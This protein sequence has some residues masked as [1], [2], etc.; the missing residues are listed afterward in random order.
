LGFCGKDVMNLIDFS[1]FG[2][3]D[4]TIYD[5]ILGIDFGHGE[6]SAALWKFNDNNNI[7]PKDLR[8][9]SNDLY[10]IYTALFVSNDGTYC[11]IGKEALGIDRAHGKLYTC[12]KAKPKYLNNLFENDII[13]KRELVQVFLSSVVKTLYKYNE[14]DLQGRTI[15]FV[16]CPSSPEWLANNGDVE[17]ARIL[18]ERV[19]TPKGEPIKIVVMPESRA[20]IIKVYKEKGEA[21]NLKK[22]VI[23]F[24][25]GSSTLDCTYINE[26]RALNDD[27]S[28]PLGA[29][30]IEEKILGKFMSNTYTKDNLNDVENTKIDLRMEKESYYENPLQTLKVT[31][32]FFV[33]NESIFETRKINQAFM[34]EVVKVQQVIYSTDSS[35]K[36]KGSWAELCE[37]FF[38]YAKRR[39]GS[40]SLGTILLTGGASR[41][42]FLQELC[43]SVFPEASLH[44]DLDPSFCVSRGL[45]WAGNSDFRC[46][47]AFYETINAIGESLF[48]KGPDYN[49]NS[50]QYRLAKVVSEGICNN[51]HEDVVEYELKNWKNSYADS[52]PNQLCSKMAARFPYVVSSKYIQDK[53][54]AIFVEEFQKNQQKTI[55]NIINEKFRSI[56]GQIIPDSYKFKISDGFASKVANAFKNLDITFDSTYCKDVVNRALGWAEGGMV[57]MDKINDS[58]SRTNK[59]DRALTEDER[60]KKLIEM[61]RSEMAS[62]IKYKDNYFQSIAKTIVSEL[63]PQI[64]ES[65]DNLALYFARS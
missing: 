10:K 12:F 61:C 43:R 60:K 29:S 11:R 30:Y 58:K 42:Q 28:E 17:Y 1:R 33:N 27:F 20:A 18:S 9:N 32:E 13:T 65:I 63:K 55:I 57:S 22:G 50:L 40:K 8:F 53:I 56:Y 37:R 41:M 36:V 34:N 15:I 16:G 62:E 26:N 24:D 19:R 5:N 44:V 46:E 51:I 2:V 25:A 7:K 59:A 35:G 21:V 54:K 6:T 48:Y 31:L 49:Y 3:T 38:Q 52:T 14:P 39:L 4:L 47:Q 45:A 23:V 64:A